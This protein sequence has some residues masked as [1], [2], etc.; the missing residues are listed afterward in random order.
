MNKR[1]IILFV[2]VAFL[3]SAL[4]RGLGLWMGV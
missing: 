2:T 1:E 3:V 4:L